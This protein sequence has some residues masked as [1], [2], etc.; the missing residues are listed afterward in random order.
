M[1]IHDYF[2]DNGTGANVR[3]DINA[4]LS[5]IVS[6]NSNPTEPGTMYAYQLWADTTSNLLKIRNSGN[7]AWITLRQLDGDFSIV[8]VEDGLQATPSLTFTND[9]NTGIFRPGNDSLAI[10][11]GATRAI[12]ITSTQAVGIQTANPS[13]A[14]HVA[15][16][17]R[18]GADDVTD[19]VL[20]IGVGATGNRSSFIDIVADTTYTDYGLRVIRNNTGANA[21]SELKH[22]GTGALNFTTEEAAPIVFYTTNSPALTITSGG[23]VGIGT[24][25]PS[26]Q[27]DVR[28]SATDFDGLRVLNTNSGSGTQTSAAIRL[29]ITN[30]F[31]AV[32]GIRNCRIQ[33][34][35]NDTD[36]NDVHLDF[37]TNS[38]VGLD[39][40]TVKMRL[41]AGGALG[42]GTTAPQTLL[43]VGD[44]TTGNGVPR[45]RVHRGSGS[46]YFEIDCTAGGTTLDTVGGGPFQISMGGSSAVYVDPSRRLLVGT[47]TSPSVGIPASALFVVQGYTGVPTGD[48]LI[49][50]QRGQAPASIT[51][52]AQLGA[53]SFG[54]NDGSPYAQIHATTDGAGAAN[55][56]PGRLV[57]STTADEAASP[58][59]RMRIDKEGTTT[60]FTSGQYGLVSK[61]SSAAG[62]TNYLILGQRDSTGITNGT[63]SFAVYSNGNVTN[64]NNSYLGIS[65]AKLK[66]NIVDANS[67]WDDL[68][69]LQVRNYNFKEGQTH[70]QIGL[71]AQEAELVSPGLV[72]ESPDRDDEG[73]DLGTVTK[74]VN[75]SVLYM[76]AV[77]ALQEAME[78]IET[79]EQR[80]IAAGI[81]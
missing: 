32:N 63:T 11:T 78:R 5:A 23:L 27:L 20:E 12:T 48:S 37:Y 59:E 45:I 52:G 19:A 75:Y 21:T 73:N 57:F 15:G 7:S 28:G 51:S 60:T 9:L 49:S 2:I 40:E 66:E 29:G 31:G 41:T 79:L 43:Q 64:T 46:D 24:S 35:E 8:A 58:T 71:V 68:K 55:D 50:L 76:K 53:I 69:A 65:D 39:L 13:T 36:S 81:D 3:A 54:A 25:G 16:N 1:P 14:L 67:Q 30:S 72:S 74:S 38:V 80:L 44:S 26:S 70:T 62:T 33:A 18:V 56:Y 10:V 42:I 47:D 61:T 6:L 22:R 17:A 34:T 4:A 77:K